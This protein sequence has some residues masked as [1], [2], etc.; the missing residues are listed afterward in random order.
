MSLEEKYFTEKQMR[1]ILA[2]ATEREARDTE[3][4]ERTIPYSQLIQIAEEAKI[5]P[6]YLKVSIKQLVQEGGGLERIATT[7]VINKSI[8]S[9]TGFLGGFLETPFMIA[10]AV[11]RFN[12]E[13]NL[14]DKAYKTGVFTWAIGTQFVGLLPTA[15]YFA[16]A[17]INLAMPTLI[18]QVATNIVSGIYEWYR[19][20][21]NKLL[22]EMDD[23][24]NS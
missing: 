17:E 9:V 10:T 21:K 19:F 8:D 5:N 12:K 20:E 6:K 7:K 15:F 24:S 13:D 18:T 2:N 14:I 23:E 16:L 3:E 22:N 4:E 1:R 11:R